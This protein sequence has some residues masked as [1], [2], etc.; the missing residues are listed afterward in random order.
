MSAPVGI[1]PAWNDWSFRLRS[2]QKHNPPGHTWHPSVNADYTL[3]GQCRTHSGCS[4]SP[5]Q[6]CDFL[7]SKKSSF[8]LRVLYKYLHYTIPPRTEQWQFSHLPPKRSHY[9][10]PYNRLGL[11]IKNLA[12]CTNRKLG[13]DILYK[14]YCKQLAFLCNMSYDDIGRLRA[15]FATHAL[16]GQHDG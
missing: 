15:K 10:K 14:I 1:R 2:P 5:A 12:K 4:P 11:Q 9:V 13:I 6:K 3:P 8:A 7:L 16:L